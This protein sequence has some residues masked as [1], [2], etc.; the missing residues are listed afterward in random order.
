MKS[1][2]LIFLLWVCCFQ[3][4]AQEEIHDYQTSDTKLSYDSLTGCFKIIS[5]TTHDTEMVRFHVDSL[6]A[7]KEDV[8][9]YCYS[10]EQESKLFDILNDKPREKITTDYCFI[11]NKEIMTIKKGGIVLFKI[12]KEAF[13]KNYKFL[14]TSDHRSPGL[15]QILLKRD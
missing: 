9:V 1:T 6:R 12:S 15:F 13:Y 7:V 5:R 11:K 10:W 14:V 2:L 8:L 3:I 4:Q